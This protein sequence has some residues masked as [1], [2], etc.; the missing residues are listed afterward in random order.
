MRRASSSDPLDHAYF[1]G[2]KE[3]FSINIL[4]ICHESGIIC[5]FTDYFG[6]ILLINRL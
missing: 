4:K 2:T 5:I 3:I 6:K 1:N